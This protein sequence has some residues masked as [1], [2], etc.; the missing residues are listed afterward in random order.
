[1]KHQGVYMCLCLAGTVVAAEI[2]PR[3]GQAAGYSSNDAKSVV[4][5]LR[6]HGVYARPLGNVVYLM[7]TPTTHPSK[8]RELL[9]TLLQAIDVYA[10]KSDT[11]HPLQ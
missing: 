5:W 7:V 9:T 4:M 6:Q 1:M 11:R 10:S 8:S 3:E 2:K